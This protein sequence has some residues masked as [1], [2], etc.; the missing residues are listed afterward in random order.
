MTPRGGCTGFSRSLWYLGLAEEG[1]GGSGRTAAGV[2]SPYVQPLAG[3]AVA[4]HETHCEK[5]PH[6]LPERYERGHLFPRIC[7][8]STVWAVLVALVSTPPASSR[9]PHHLQPRRRHPAFCSPTPSCGAAPAGS[10]DVAF[11]HLPLPLCH[12]QPPPPSS[13]QPLRSVPAA[14]ALAAV[15]SAPGAE[16]SQMEQL[17]ELQNRSMELRRH[18][19]QVRGEGPCGGGGS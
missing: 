15:M 4:G 19:T 1:E 3:P 9:P 17:R 14:P 10:V 18:L 2:C 16:R 7:C 5:R 13:L 8:V 6:I 11:I 12:S